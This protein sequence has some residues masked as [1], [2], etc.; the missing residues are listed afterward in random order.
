MNPF[1][2]AVS[3][4]GQVAVTNNGPSGDAGSPPTGATFVDSSGPVAERGHLVFCTFNSGM[5][6]L[7]PGS[8]H[9]TVT[10]G[11]A[12]CKLDAKQAR[13]HSHYYSDMG[14]IYRLAA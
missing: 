8:P 13:D 11:P 14:H 6:I 3:P 2:I 1:G 9:A 7:T 4:S 10:A 5:M 12:N